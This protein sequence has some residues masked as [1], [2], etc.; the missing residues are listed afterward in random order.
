MD[1]SFHVFMSISFVQVFSNAQLEYTTCS[2]PTPP[3]AKKTHINVLLE[4][5]GGLGEGSP[6][7]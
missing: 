4:L 2:L 3:S 6:E 7:K 5:G 1:E